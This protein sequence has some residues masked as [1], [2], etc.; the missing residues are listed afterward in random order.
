MGDE[1]QFCVHIATPVEKIDMMEQKILSSIKNNKRHWY[2]ETKLVYKDIEDLNKLR[3][4]V[5]LKHKMNYQDIEERGN[6][7]SHLLRE[8]TN[9]LRELEII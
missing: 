5:S 7:K 2:S 8:I 4:K 6:R 1:I 3:L 9:I